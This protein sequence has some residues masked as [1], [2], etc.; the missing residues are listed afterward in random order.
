VLRKIS[1]ALLASAAIVGLSTA[2]FAADVE[3]V[4]VT[5]TRIPHANVEAPTAVTT[6]SS[7]VLQM[8][9][10][11]NVSDM[12]RS[13]PSF[14]V[15]GISATNSNFATAGAGISTLELRNLGEDRT[16][17]LVNGRRYVAGV[18]GSSAVDFNTVPTDL[19]DRVEVITGGASA[20]Y[21]SDALAGVINVILKT[22]Y[23][24]MTAD[25]QTGRTEYDD[26]VTYKVHAMFGSNFANNKGNLVVSATW[27]RNEGAWAKN[28]GPLRSDL[29]VSGGKSSYS[30]YGRLAVQADFDTTALATLDPTK[31]GDIENFVGGGEVDV[32][33]SGVG[34][35]GTVS[36]YSGAY[37]FDRQPWRAIETPVDR[38][39]F[40]T[41]GHY[42]LTNSLQFYMETTFANTKSAA[43]IEPYPHDSADLNNIP[44]S[45]G[46]GGGISIY[47]PYVPASIRAASLASQANLYAARDAALAQAAA[48]AT[49]AL[50]DA[51]T[52][53]ADTLNQLGL[54]DNYITYRRRLTEFGPRHYNASRDLYRLVVGAKGT[55]F[56]NYNW[57]LYFNWGHTLDTQ[58]GTG[59]INIPNLREAVQAHTAT[60]ADISAGA[61]VGGGPAKVGDIICDN[62]YAQA[63]GCVPINLF[64]LN[65]VTPEALKYV[66][67]PQSRIDNIDQ[68]VIAGSISGP[69]F[70]LPAGDVSGVVG[71]EY[72]RE[73]A[74]DVP[75]AL[76]QSGQNAGNKEPETIG[77]Y[78]V[79]EF[80]AETEVPILKNEFL[81]KDLSLG[82]AVRWSQYG[83][84][85][86]TT[87]TNAYT[88]RISWS[89]LD[90]LRFRAQYAKAVRAA[91]ITEMFAPGGEDFASV[92]DPCD[93]VTP[94]STGSIAA[95]CLADPA[96]A[97]RVAATGS[98]TLSLAEIQGTG[99]T[100]GKGKQ[101][102]SPEK[103]DTYTLG[104]VFNHDFGSYGSFML[105][106]DYYDIDIQ[107]VI[108]RVGRQQAINLCYKGT[109]YPNAF[110]DMV[111]RKSTGGNFQRGAI[112][113][114]NTG[115]FNQGYVKENG[116]DIAISHNFD[117]NEVDWLKGGLGLDDAGQIST[118]LN[119]TYTNGFSDESFG[120]VT[121][122][123]GVIGAPKH[124]AQFG[125]IY[126][127]GPL[128]LQWETDFQSRV[129]LEPTDYTVSI[130]PYYLHNLS[131][132][133]QVSDEL[134]FFGGV[135][136]LLNIRAPF[137]P[138]AY[139]TTGTTTV[140]DVYDAIG[141]RF[142]LGARF[143]M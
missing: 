112:I 105:S 50:A 70:K 24:G 11:V 21:G 25:V 51:W 31:P 8:S 77:S 120:E 111:V 63:E 101:D 103:S 90:D 20:I 92:D 42:N 99:G 74:S 78:H 136:N 3:T 60:A 33:G 141:R 129:Y 35:T 119:W 47:N 15:S 13:V 94:T 49:P 66:M 65:S 116:I 26:E 2:A 81:A 17:V 126:Q 114:V 69:V 104:A 89:P 73:Y 18:A 40:S 91:N 84:G 122:D 88:G 134:E 10:T 43:N 64:G 115:Y 118:R 6:I 52:T 32:V 121:N 38:L 41:N 71:F 95:H 135:N 137:V 7:E 86:A 124:K 109:S 79:L 87:I 30:A 39:V 110:C 139:A 108:T 48:A 82:G 29:T 54:A 138:N 4:T 106:V 93:G 133:Y 58:Q 16:L 143:K 68:Q 55:L 100:N 12:L 59:Q 45:A 37:G 44:A 23:E 128:S 85:T 76:S 107:N 72:R 9:G 46:G 57:D 53:E 102:L 56:D 1:S 80:F 75:D 123:N 131:G 62:A 117:L 140:A 28:R 132:S 5:G 19:I 83:T 125:L 67:A 113:E 96:V 27:S 14:G 127:N 34:P 61:L 36:P 130:R 97:A 142:F 98:L 22:D